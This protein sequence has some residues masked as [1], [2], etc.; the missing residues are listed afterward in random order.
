MN[1]NMGPSHSEITMATVVYIV[2]T[3]FLLADNRNNVW[4][5]L[6]EQSLKRK[7]NEVGLFLPA[8]FDCITQSK[9]L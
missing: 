5:E 8:V 6:C 3:V 9:L 2:T 7:Y 1:Q 4:T